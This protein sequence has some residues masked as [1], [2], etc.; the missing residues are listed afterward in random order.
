MPDTQT[1]HL[2]RHQLRSKRRALSPQLQLDHGRRVASQI[3]R[4]GLLLY[5][6]HIALY[7]Q[8]D[9]EISTHAIVSQ[10]RRNG[11]SLYLPRIRSDQHLQFSRWHATSVLIKNSY[12]IPES[13]RRPRSLYSLDAILLPIVGYDG[14]GN[15]LGMGGGYYDRTLAQL[16]A[17]QRP[18]LLGLAHD[19]QAL[20]EI[21]PEAWDIALDAI[22]TESGIIYP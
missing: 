20:D 6:Q 11:R 12:G 3:A 8:Q 13:R 4:S 17:N 18:L 14:R 1:R 5:A 2:T 21:E 10:L 9:G 15:R 19:C 16:P 22:A 7:R